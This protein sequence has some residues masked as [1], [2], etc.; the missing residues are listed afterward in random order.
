MQPNTAL[1]PGVWSCLSPACDKNPCKPSGKVSLAPILLKWNH[2]S[3]FI[4]LPVSKTYLR[5]RSVGGKKNPF[6]SLDTFKIHKSRGLSF[7]SAIFHNNE[8]SNILCKNSWQEIFPPHFP[9]ALFHPI[10]TLAIWQEV[11]WGCL[12]LMDTNPSR[13]SHM[14]IPKME[15]KRCP[16]ICIQAINLF[17]VESAALFRWSPALTFCVCCAKLPNLWGLT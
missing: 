11:G 2:F 9:L 1:K 14:H 6:S 12:F 3:P 5:L 10:N 16:R 13:S 7:L 8:N 17:N 4:T 15:K